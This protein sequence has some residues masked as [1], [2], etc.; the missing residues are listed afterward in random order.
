M[1]FTAAEVAYRDDPLS[2]EPTGQDTSF[3]QRNPKGNKGPYFPT[4][5]CVL[6]CKC[7]HCLP[8]L[9]A[10]PLQDHTAPPGSTKARFLTAG[11]AWSQQT[12][13]DKHGVCAPGSAEL[14]GEL[15]LAA[16]PLAGTWQIPHLVSYTSCWQGPAQSRHRAITAREH[17]SQKPVPDGCRGAVLEAQTPALPR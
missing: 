2:A 3:R 15:M 8:P 9:P 10:W 7:P 5:I 1:V 6:I 16:H 4:H 14:Q 13:P 11:T 12:P 17:D